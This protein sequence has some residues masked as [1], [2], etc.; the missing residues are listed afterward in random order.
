MSSILILFGGL[1]WMASVIIAYE[2]G[3][4]RGYAKGSNASKRE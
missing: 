4:K 2:V 1:L 3:F